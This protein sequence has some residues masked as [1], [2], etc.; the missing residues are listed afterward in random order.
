MY[1]LHY[2]NRNTLETQ[3]KG[4]NF[5]H[6]FPKFNTYFY[7]KTAIEAFFISIKCKRK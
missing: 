3:I 1:Y 4:D 2:N 7:I 6:R 5:K